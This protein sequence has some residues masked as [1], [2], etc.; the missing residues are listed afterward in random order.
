MGNGG[1]GLVAVDGQPHELGAG[2]GER[3]DLAGG[4]LDVGGVGVGHR[5]DDD[6]RAAADQDRRSAL[7][8][9]GRRRSCGGEAGRRAARS[10]R[11]P[12][13]HP[14][15]AGAP[16]CSTGVLG[17]RR[18]IC[19]PNRRLPLPSFIAM[20]YDRFTRTG[21]RR[22]R[23]RVGSCSGGSP[24][25]ARQ[26]SRRRHRF[27][28]RDRTR[29][30]PGARQGRRGRDDQRLRRRQGDRGGARRRSKRSSAS[31]AS[32]TAPTCRKAPRPRR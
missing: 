31:S 16:R 26:T 12:S 8:R 5:L 19:H 9:R 20:Q 28:E 6:R 14:S 3:G 24:Y 10:G 17:P 23:R 2:A 11:N 29:H 30:R 1:G 18:R 25:V 21:L 32:T 4:R 27:H 13:V 7:R 22:R 15:G